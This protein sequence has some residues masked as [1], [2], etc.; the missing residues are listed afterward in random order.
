MACPI[1]GLIIDY[2]QKT[3]KQNDLVDVK[4]MIIPYLMVVGSFSVFVIF[5][6]FDNVYTLWIAL[7]ALSVNSTWVYV[8]Y[9]TGQFL[10]L[11]C[12]RILQK[13]FQ[14]SDFNKYTKIANFSEILP[15]GFSLLLRIFFRIF[16]QIFDAFLDVEKEIRKK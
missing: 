2:T 14:I 1:L 5:L 12:R 15:N 11:S 8:I 4:A 6:M 10:L 3:F 9:T 13:I 7:V 16:L